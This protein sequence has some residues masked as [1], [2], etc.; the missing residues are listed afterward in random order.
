MLDTLTSPYRLILRDVKWQIASE[1]GGDMGRET[2]WW[3]AAELEGSAQ[4]YAW[5]TRKTSSEHVWLKTCFDT[6]CDR[7]YIYFKKNKEQVEKK[8]G[9]Q[10][11][12]SFILNQLK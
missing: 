1:L 6:E 2:K 9:Q 10:W 12:H 8:K 5:K 3:K 11:D 7:K 4:F